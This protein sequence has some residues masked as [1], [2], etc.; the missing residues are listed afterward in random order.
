MYKRIKTNDLVSAAEEKAKL[1]VELIIAN[2]ENAKREAELL[3]AN[4]EKAK[5]A[6]KL[7][8]ANQE[9]GKRAAELVI[10]N[11]DKAKRAAELVIDNADKAKCAAVLVIANIEKEHR[12]DELITADREI[13]FQNEEKLKLSSELVIADVNRTKRE[14]ELVIANIEKTKRIAKLIITE[15]EL[16]LQ[17]EKTSKY[18]AK[19]VIANAEK[20]KRSAELVIANIKKAELSAELAIAN[21]EK[22][23]RSAELV[24]ANKE[25][26]YQKSEESKRSAELV[27]SK[28]L[29]AKNAAELVRANIEKAKRAAEY[30]ILSKEVVLSQEKGKLID[31][32]TSVNE[33]LSHE[34]EKRKQSDEA[35]REREEEFRSLAESMPQIVWTTR[36]DGWNTYFNQHWVDYTGLTLEQSYGHGWNI[37]FH[38][39]DKQL[40]WDAWQNA[41]NN[42][43]EYSIECR[44]R[45]HDGTYHW[46]LIRGVPQIRTDGEIVK[47]FGTCTDIEK[48]KEAELALKESEKQLLRL[49]VDKDRF[50]SILGHDLKGPFNTILGFSEVLTEDIRKLDI[51]EIEDIAGNINKSAK[52]TNK[53]LEDILMW[54][55]TQ[56]GSIPFNPLNLNLS[57]ICRNIFEVLNP[58]ACAKNITINCSAADNINL[59]ADS[60]MLKTV[61]LNLVS[62]S[63]KF[64]NKS[65]K[66]TINS[67]QDSENIRI[68]VSD[69]GVGIPKD[70]LSKLF[71][72]SEILSTKGTAGETGTGIGLLLCKEFVEKHGGK[73]WVKSEVGKGSDF[74]FTLPLLISPKSEVRSP[75]KL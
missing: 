13:I 18:A 22:A 16:S 30:V 2:E 65:G 66:I 5:R 9:K 23:K 54:A 11:G 41:V 74:K 68:S 63:I 73:I 40:A 57:A 36:A 33:E 19:L 44:L 56:Q 52:I 35:L 20:A 31:E 26:V 38:P 4:A 28:V 48:M 71:D 6:A 21:I 39:E 70:N 60:D 17:K 43:A 75:K 27:I 47:W 32:L 64:T 46:W 15:T 14:A 61:L 12:A 53:L 37:P 45:C 62:N 7:V 51:D 25:L 67:E 49:N 29:K 3:I 10:S 55:R 59:Y 24:I 8:I 69:N 1:V 34:I 42:N 50:I 58:V 72:I